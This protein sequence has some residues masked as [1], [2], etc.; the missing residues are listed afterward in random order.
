VQVQLAADRVRFALVTT[1]DAPA[2]RVEDALPDKM[3]DG[4]ARLEGRV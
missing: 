2:L 4:A 3:L 1:E